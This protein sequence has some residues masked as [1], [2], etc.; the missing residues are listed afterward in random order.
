MRSTTIVTMI[1]QVFDDGE[2][3]P[4]LRDAFHTNQV[5]MNAPRPIFGETIQGHWIHGGHWRVIREAEE[6]AIEIIEAN[7]DLD[8]WIVRPVSLATAI[9]MLIARSVSMGQT[10]SLME[11]VYRHASDAS[12][13]RSFNAHYSNVPTSETQVTVEQLQVLYPQ[14]AWEG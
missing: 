1:S 12:V 14:Y 10:S 7:F 6:D 8:A 2:L 5:V 9:E 4:E 11:Q 13:K 3:S